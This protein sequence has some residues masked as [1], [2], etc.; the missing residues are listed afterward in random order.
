MLTLVQMDNT[1]EG[2]VRTLQWV[3]ESGRKPNISASVREILLR[4]DAARGLVSSP[5]S[6]DDHLADYVQAV[7]DAERESE[8][9]L[10]RKTPYV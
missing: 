6:W 10:L 9:L 4:A 3:E 7:V 2:I 5:P 1:K 8:K